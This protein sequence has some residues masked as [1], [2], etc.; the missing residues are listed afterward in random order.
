MK[1]WKPKKGDI[2][3]T[4]L[5]GE[6]LNHMST[7]E[8]PLLYDIWCG[9]WL[10]SVACGRHIILPRPHAPVF[11]NMY[12]VLAAESG[13]TRKSSAVRKCSKI[14][15]EFHQL[16]DEV[17]RPFVI[18]NKTTPEAITHKLTHQSIDKG[19][20]ECVITIDE[21]VT[22]FG[23]EKYNQAM[24]GLLTD[25]YDCPVMRSGG[26]SLVRGEVLLRNVWINILTA[27]TPSWLTSAINPDIVEG[28]FT[29][30]T[31]FVVNEVRKQLVAWPED[32]QTATVSGMAATMRHIRSKARL[33]QE[34]GISDDALAFY[35]NWYR[36]RYIYRDPYRASFDSREDAHILRIASLLSINDGRYKIHRRDVVFAIRLIAAV[37]EAGA[38][39][40]EGSGSNANLIIGLDRIRDILISAGRDYVKR[41]EITLKVRKWINGAEIGAAIDVM[42][43][44]GMIQKFTVEVGRGRPAE[45]YRATRSLAQRTA[46]SEVM[47][48]MEN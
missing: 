19:H 3:N 34:V 32:T 2:P 29:S 36:S 37:K 11:L 26:G 23:R 31:Y 43:E 33:Y 47:A 22:F 35:K 18:E 40:F 27:S 1:A 25:L 21:M 30:R 4:G 44:L 16:L 13:I 24:P 6:Y 45:V 41:S 9:L 38:T 12:V 46:I 39:L 48:S 17:E 20:A 14:T 42:H 15:R 5:I 10:V 28:G 7:T 8:T